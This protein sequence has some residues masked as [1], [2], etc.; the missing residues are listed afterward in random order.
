MPRT[1]FNPQTD[2]FAFTNLFRFDPV[3][4]ATLT[5]VVRGA[6][7]G[8]GFVLPLPPPPVVDPV[9]AIVAAVVQRLAIDK[10][11]T[12]IVGAIAPKEYGLC[13]GMAFSALDY[14]VKGWV[15][16]R[17]N[18]WDDQPQRT[19]PTA[20]ALRSYLWSRLVK[21]LEDNA[22]AFV[23]WMAML[24]LPGGP[25]PAWL[26]DQTR[27]HLAVLKARIDGGMPIPLGLVGTTLNPTEN[28]QVLCSGY[29]DHRDG[30]TTLYLYDPNAPGVESTTTL[31]FSG[32]ALIA[33]ESAPSPQRG[34]LRGVFCITYTP[35]TPPRTLVLRSGL[36]ATPPNAGIDQ[37]LRVQFTAANVGFRSSPD[38][39]LVAAS[40]TGAVARE[41]VPA[42]IAEGAS[43]ALSSPLTLGSPG[44]HRI[45]VVAMLTVDGVQVLK[46]LPPEGGSQSP[47]AAVAI[48]AAREI[49]FV[50]DRASRVP[51]VQGAL[52]ALTTTADDMGPGVV[53]AWS[54]TGATI[55]G[56]STSPRFQVRLPDRPDVTVTVTVRCALPDGAVSTGTRSFQT[57]SMQEALLG[58]GLHDIA[59]VALSPPIKRV[60]PLGP[61]AVVRRD[62]GELVAIRDWAATLVDAA[63]AAIKASAAPKVAPGLAKKM[64]APGVAAGVE[65]PPTMARITTV[66][67][68]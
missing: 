29:D 35:Q 14:F 22:A 55:E 23:Q 58:E 28:H 25:G 61:G 12:E 59:R 53:Y 21:S 13:G 19:S 37:P 54:V 2:G 68:K 10:I 67:P 18:G 24:H 33:A 27:A 9:S 57:V 50:T 7:A 39:T 38:V 43:R 64:V 51:N 63:N 42:P 60:D 46:Q 48:F 5:N 16:P 11:T 8:V 26:R 6:V 49:R 41:T 52:A 40:D 45:G 1:G 3:E 56:G 65:M 36:T 15:V 44:N 34:P 30:T 31:D 62:P 32:P 66:K 4:T 20:E 47:T 17:G